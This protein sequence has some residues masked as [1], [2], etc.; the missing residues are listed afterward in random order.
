MIDSQNLTW[1]DLRQADNIPSSVLEWLDDG[2]SL[3][4]KLQQKFDDFTV[5]VLSQQPG[6][7]YANE[8]GLLGFNGP[9][10]IRQVELLG[11]G[12]VVVFARSVIPINDDTQ[13]LLQI[14]SRPLGDI[15]FNDVNVKRGKLQ[16]SHTGDIWARRSTFSINTTKVLVSEF[17]LK[18][19]GSLYAR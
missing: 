12:Q 14:G 7:P 15:L 2:Q 1:T 19:L 8:V 3:T 18:Q 10:I 6:N 17:F 5:N 4:A 9:S 16:I 13:S 11:G